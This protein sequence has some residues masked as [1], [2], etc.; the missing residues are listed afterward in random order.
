M[1]TIE[2]GIDELSIDNEE[3]VAK[4]TP[5][6]IYSVACH[7]NETK[8]VAGAGDKVRWRRLLSW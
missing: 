2:K 8:I 4:V 1:K 6:R 5:D 3:W 7:P